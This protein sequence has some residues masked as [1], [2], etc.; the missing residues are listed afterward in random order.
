MNELRELTA[1]WL[2]RR[3]KLGQRAADLS[4]VSVQAN[5][6]HAQRFC[7][8]F[9]EIDKCRSELVAVINRLEKKP[10]CNKKEE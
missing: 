2:R 7:G 4:R 5:Q 9:S 8:K 3:K 1:K 6:L 10:L